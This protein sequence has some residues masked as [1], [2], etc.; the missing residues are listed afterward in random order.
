VSVATGLRI[1]ILGSGQIVRNAILDAIVEADGASVAAIATRGNGT[2]LLTD[3][4]LSSARILTGADSYARLVEAEDVD[5]VYIGL[6]NH[7]HK[8][9]TLAAIEHGKH[10]LCEKPLGIDA[11]EAMA[12]VAAA[13]QASVRLVEAFMY[14]YNPQHQRVRDIIASGELGE[15]KLVRSGFT[16]PLE[17]PLAN[18][19]FGPY[20]AAGALFDVGVYCVNVARWMF[21]LEPSTAYAS[22]TQ[23]RGSEGDILHSLVLTFP[24]GGLASLSGGLGQAYQSFYEVI[25]TDGRVLVDRPFA[26]PPFV[27][28]QPQLELEVHSAG[29]VRREPFPDAGQYVAQ[30]EEFVKLLDGRPS[31]AY[32]ADDSVANLDVIDALA[33][34]SR[35]GKAETVQHSYRPVIGEETVEKRQ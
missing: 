30:I 4:R 14:R 8:P 12:M 25:G 29:T 17:D 21:G 2:D 15:V 18:V 10:V 34:S 5:A 23:L 33:R 6:P 20:P 35:S 1:G 9:W 28:A 32:L 16:V 27:P 3:P 22:M 11:G 19:R 7:L 31:R 24:G 26:T 13:R